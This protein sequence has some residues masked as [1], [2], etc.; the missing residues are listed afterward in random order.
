M[1]GKGNSGFT[2]IEVAIVMVILALLSGGILVGKLLIHT[3]ELRATTR[4]LDMMNA[5]YSTFRL[6]FSCIPGD[7]PNAT[8]FGFQPGFAIDFAQNI[9]DPGVLNAL[10]PVSNAHAFSMVSLIV[11]TNI[12]G[13]DNRRLD[14]ATYENFISV[15]LLNQASMLQG[16]D[17][18]VRVP[19]K[20]S[21]ALGVTFT[22]QYKQAFWQPYYLTP[23]TNSLIS[24]A[25]HYFFALATAFP[26][27]S[28]GTFLTEDAHSMDIKIDDGM[29]ITGN[30]RA[31][32]SQFGDNT[33]G[34]QYLAGRDTGPNA[35]LEADSSGGV[36]TSVRYNLSNIT[37]R[38]ALLVKAQGI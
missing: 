12:N 10:S 6:K 35:C 38:C 31:S 29:P 13:D 26:T 36:T 27:I 9:P 20:L 11:V 14:N 2:L 32:T 34:P 5:A 8:A 33:Q 7:C 3:A 19:I 37:V 25:G 21:T 15:A 23:G 30:M 24:Q 17:L 16:Y 1:R 18:K 28:T 4:Q 22:G